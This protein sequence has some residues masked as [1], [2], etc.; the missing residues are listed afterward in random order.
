MECSKLDSV[1]TNELSSSEGKQMMQVVR[2]IAAK[3]FAA[4]QYYFVGNHY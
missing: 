2:S 3:N 4:C 1:L